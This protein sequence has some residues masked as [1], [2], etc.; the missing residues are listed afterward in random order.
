M[1]AL[2]R[3]RTSIPPRFLGQRRETELAKLFSAIHDG[4]IA[5]RTVKKKILD[6]GKWSPAKAQLAAE[7]HGK[8]A[9]CESPTTATN[10]GDVEHYRPKSKF[11]WFAYCYENFLLSCT[12]CN[13]TKGNQH[14]AGTAFVEPVPPWPDGHVPTPAEVLAF[15]LSIDP[16]PADPA[17]VTA[18]VQA[19]LDEEIHLPNP[20]YEDP[21]SLFAW[22]ADALLQEV[23]VV[24]ADNSTRSARAMA[25]AEAIVALNRDELLKQ[26][27][28][29]FITARTIIE[30]NARDRAQGLPVAQ[31]EADLERL[32]LSDRFPFAAMIRYFAPGWQAAVP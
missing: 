6:S 9:F 19:C 8:C 27:Y 23:R 20:Y 30:R 22:E 12:L 17:A 10:Y 21:E 3:D 7:T 15:A 31:R 13:G 11:P 5:T 26:R 4:S 24:A 28:F 16:D 32:M 25:A 29:T 18:Y 1:I 14:I 2:Q